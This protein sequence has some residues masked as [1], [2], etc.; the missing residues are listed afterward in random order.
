LSLSLTSKANIHFIQIASQM[1]IFQ[2][3]YALF[4]FP[5]SIACIAY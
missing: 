1:T 3:S 2:Y 5:L 4:A